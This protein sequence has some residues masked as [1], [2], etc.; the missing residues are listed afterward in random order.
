MGQAEW[1]ERYLN[2]DQFLCLLT[3]NNL[4]ILKYFHLYYLP[5]SNILLYCLNNFL[6]IYFFWYNN[7]NISCSLMFFY[8]NILYWQGRFFVL[9]SVKG[10][11]TC[12]MPVYHYQP[13]FGNAKIVS[14]GEHI[15][16]SLMKMKNEINQ[17]LVNQTSSSDISGKISPFRTF[18]RVWKLT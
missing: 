7:P 5:L 16:M 13:V 2:F 3:S 17:D 14:R 4:N 9:C 10:L 15:L 18:G 12:R 6:S 11:K 8:R 1:S